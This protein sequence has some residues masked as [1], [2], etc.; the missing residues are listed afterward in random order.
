MALQKQLAEKYGVAEQPEPAQP[1]MT[2]FFRRVAPAE[3]QH[4]AQQ[5]MAADKE[6]LRQK[7]IA[8]KEVTAARPK[9]LRLPR[10]Q[11]PAPTTNPKAK[12]RLLELVRALR[13]SLEPLLSSSALL[14]AHSMRCACAHVSLQVWP[15]HC[16]PDPRPPLARPPSVQE[17]W[18]A[19]SADLTTVDV[20]RGQRAMA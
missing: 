5:Q 15:L 12:V 6:E 13:D 8:E 4:A 17:E 20:E 1:K 19:F 2:S 11:R 3:Q 9:R 10:L 14:C 7:R 16:T 18:G